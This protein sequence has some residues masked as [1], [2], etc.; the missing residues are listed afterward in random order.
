MDQTTAQVAKILGVGCGGVFS[1]AMIELVYSRKLKYYLA[2]QKF[3]LIVLTGGVLLGLIVLLKLRVLLNPHVGHSHDHGHDHA[4]DHSHDDGHGHDHA[5]NVSL[6]R[7]IVLMFPLM[8]IFMGLMPKGLSANALEKRA[9]RDQLD[10]IAAAGATLPA[11]RSL[12]GRVVGS[13]LKELSDAAFEPNRREFWESTSSPVRAE[14][15]GQFI[16][17]NRFVDRYRLMR[18]KITC[19]AADGTPVAVTV[20]G[21]PDPTWKYGDWIAVVGPISFFESK[22]SRTGAVKFHPALH[23]QTTSRLTEQPPDFYLQ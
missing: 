5:H 9:T 22:D 4:H 15:V 17:D 16:P 1:Y 6:W 2:D 13:N 7:F 10:A 11:G 21:K 3:E 20:L 8:I 19:C 12:E 14:I 23:Q 18:I